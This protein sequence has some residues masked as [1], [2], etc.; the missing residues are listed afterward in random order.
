MGF[1]LQRDFDQG[2]IS[3]L[4][5][6][7]S[8]IQTALIYDTRDFEP[9]PTSGYYLKLQMNIPVSILVRSL[10]L[11]NCFYKEKGFGSCL[12]VKDSGSE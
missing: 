7:I 9:D 11:T 3:G 5:G 1:P 6:G 4:N 12:S 10:N 2:E 8:I